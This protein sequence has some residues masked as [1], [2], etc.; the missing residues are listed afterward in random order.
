MTEVLNL[1]K[2]EMG[3]DDISVRVNAIY[4]LKIVINLITAD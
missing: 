2:S 1:F 3:S 4:R